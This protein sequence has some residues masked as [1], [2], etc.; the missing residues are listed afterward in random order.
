MQR[1]WMERRCPWT[2]TCLVRIQ[3]PKA[4]MDGLRTEEL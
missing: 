3:V 1:R 2:D 4:I